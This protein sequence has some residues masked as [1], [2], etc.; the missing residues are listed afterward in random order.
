MDGDDVYL[1]PEASYQVAQRLARDGGEPI[2]VGSKTLHKRLHEKGLLTS[3]EPE[4]HKLTI[5]R[6]VE[7]QRRAV[8][9][10]TTALFSQP[11]GPNRPKA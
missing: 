5:R 9:H 3:T 11:E 6:T 10:L 4:R 8:L 2:T 7:R 1:E